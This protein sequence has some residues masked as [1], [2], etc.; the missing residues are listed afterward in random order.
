MLLLP[1]FLLHLIFLL[2]PCLL[3]GQEN[4]HDH[5]DFE[6]FCLIA[7][8]SLVIKNTTCSVAIY[9]LE[10]C[11]G[12]RR[13]PL[14]GQAPAMRTKGPRP[15]FHEK[16]VWGKVLRSEHSHGHNEGKDGDDA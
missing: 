15:F 9:V 6:D 11:T 7:V 8:F 12:G 5:R 10:S 2:V 4:H 16:K 3:D 14:R 13:L 1:K